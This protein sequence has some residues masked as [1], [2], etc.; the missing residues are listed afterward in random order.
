MYP[1]F[2]VYVKC[3]NVFSLN[4]LSDHPEDFYLKTIKKIMIVQC[5]SEDTVN[6]FNINNSFLF[7]N[8]LEQFITL[9][10]FNHGRSI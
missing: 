2:P 9:V 8:Y 3:K 4:M 5:N 10:Q 6:Y 7:L 1:V